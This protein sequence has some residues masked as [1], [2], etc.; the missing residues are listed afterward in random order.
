M[1]KKWLVLLASLL[2]LNTSVPVYAT[3]PVSG[4]NETSV[5]IDIPTNVNVNS[6]FTFSILDAADDSAVTTITLDTIPGVT[7]SAK[8]DLKVRVATNTPSYA[9]TVK[10]N[11]QPTHTDGTT[12]LPYISGSAGQ[13]TFVTPVDG[14]DTGFGYTAKQNVGTPTI[15]AGFTAGTSYASFNTTDDAVMSG[16]ATNE[17]ESLVTVGAWVD[18]STK[19]GVYANTLT[20]TMTPTY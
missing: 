8:K 3:N 15:P 12:S 14:T 6:A 17:D 20:F 10:E 16:V 18:Y 11:K 19:N 13:N 9:V 1:K 7:N 4:T 5:G 2:I